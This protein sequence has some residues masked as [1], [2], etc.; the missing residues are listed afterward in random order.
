MTVRCNPLVSLLVASAIGSTAACAAEGIV[1]IGHS[2]VPTLDADT[3]NRIFTHRIVV[4]KGVF[5]T[6]VNASKGDVVRSR[7]LRNFLGQSD[8][9]YTAYMLSRQSVGLG[10]PPQELLSRI[11]VINFVSST[12]GAIGYI[13]ETDIRPGMNIVLKTPLR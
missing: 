2:S 5:V 1:V 3:V 6:A 12:P 8:D 13:E 7:F 9:Q 4:V 10:K 11:D